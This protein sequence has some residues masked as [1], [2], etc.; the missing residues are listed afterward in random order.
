MSLTAKV[1]TFL[2]TDDR[3]LTQTSLAKKEVVLYTVALTRGW[4]SPL[5]AQKPGFEVSQHFLSLTLKAE[6]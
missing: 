5:R 2:C 3:N 4:L 1:R 6:W